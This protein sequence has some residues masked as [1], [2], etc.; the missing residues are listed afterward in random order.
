MVP[1]KRFIHIP[2]PALVKVTLF[3]KSFFVNVIKDLE[4]KAY[5]IIQR[6]LNPKTSVLIRH[7]R[8]EDTERRGERQVTIDTL[9]G[10]MHSQAKERLK[11]LE[12]GRRK[13]E[14]PPRSLREHSPVSPWF[15]NSSL[16]NCEITNFCCL[17]HLGFGN[18]LWAAL[19]N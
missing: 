19:G 6:A 15:Q 1:P 7:R 3:G 10:V 16:Q 8:G 18:L 5:W 14:F 4:I 12:A 17:N 9:I 13:E 2:T 11:P